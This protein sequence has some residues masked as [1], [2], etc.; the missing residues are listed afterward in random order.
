MCGEEAATLKIKGGYA[1]VPPRRRCG[2]SRPVAQTSSVR[3][4]SARPPRNGAALPVR[5]R[6]RCTEVEAWQAEGA[7]EPSSASTQR[8]RGGMYSVESSV[9]RNGLEWASTST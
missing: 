9:R 3:A 6:V 4:A 8:G 1:H 5:R 2:C 7:S